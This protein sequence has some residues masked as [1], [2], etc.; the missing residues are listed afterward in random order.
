MKGWDIMAKILDITDTVI[1][2][3]TDD[4]GIKEIRTSDINFVP[5]I[6]DKVEI[7]ETETRTIVSKVD[8]KKADNAMPAGGININM[9]NNQTMQTPQVMLANGTVAVNKLVYCL[10]CFFLGG[11][12]AHKFY[13]HKT[14]SGILYLL[15]CWTFIPALIAFIEFIVALCKKP[16]ANGLILV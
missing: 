3:G 14:G 10:L 12:G 4:G 15:F 9:N 2:I 6:G 16:D 5:H 1:S 13:A 7:F 11:I 8:E